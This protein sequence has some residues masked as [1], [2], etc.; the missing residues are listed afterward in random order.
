ML[1]Q[2]RDTFLHF[3]YDNLPQ[4]S[5]LHYIVRDPNRPSANILQMNALNVEYLG[6]V[7]SYNSDKQMVAIDIVADSEDSAISWVQGLMS[8]LRCAYYTP[9]FD[10]TNPQAP[11]SVR[12][13]IMWPRTSINFQRVNSD[14]YSHYTCLLTLEFSI[15]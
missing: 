10:Y 14:N 7:S 4:G 5:A 8:L 15:I 12:G 13:N 6:V 2:V 1:Q 9:T 3:L 11:T